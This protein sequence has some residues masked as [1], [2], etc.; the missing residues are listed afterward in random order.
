MDY[1]KI[2]GPWQKRQRLQDDKAVFEKTVN[3]ILDHIPADKQTLM[4]GLVKD[5]STVDMFNNG[6]NEA[7][8]KVVNEYAEKGEGVRETIISDAREYF[9]KYDTARDDDMKY[10]I[11]KDCDYDD[12]DE[13]DQEFLD[14]FFIEANFSA[15]LS[16]AGALQA[17][18]DV[19]ETLEL[20]AKLDSVYENSLNYDKFKLKQYN[21][22][23]KEMLTYKETDSYEYLEQYEN[24]LESEF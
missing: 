1:D 9:R 19:N 22:D 2:P 16:S 8:L 11:L 6:Y 10:D 4:I 17:L 12:L 23:L 3:A 5:E 18:I 14:D 24:E 7:I 20:G 15:W 13:Y 21:E